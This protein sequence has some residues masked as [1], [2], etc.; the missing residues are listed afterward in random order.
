MAVDNLEVQRGTILVRAGKPVPVI[1]R[2]SAEA[3]EQCDKGVDDGANALH[4]T[5]RGRQEALSNDGDSACPCRGRT[6][7]RRVVCQSQRRA[8]QERST[9][10]FAPEAYGIELR[11]SACNGKQPFLCKQMSVRS[12]FRIIWIRNSRLLAESKSYSAEP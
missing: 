3:Y 6:G 7:S 5:T 4:V 1:G 11:C 12:S 10:S 9:P 8:A 2:G